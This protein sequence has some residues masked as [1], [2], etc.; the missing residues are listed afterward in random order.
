M[1]EE[2]SAA[3]PKIMLLGY[4]LLGRK[5]LRLKLA[6]YLILRVSRRM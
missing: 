2:I 1:N 3:K 4:K 6:Q 5:V